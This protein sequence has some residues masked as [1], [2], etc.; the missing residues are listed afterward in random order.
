MEQ[1]FQRCWLLL[2]HESQIP[3]PGDFVVTRMGTEEVIMVRDRKDLQIRAFLNSCRP[4]GEKVCRY[5]Q[6]NSLVF[7]CPFHA[8]EYD[9][10]GKLVGVRHDR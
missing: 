8:L 1:I 3:N 10:K 6:G 9:T 2:G 7:T 5:D 4:P